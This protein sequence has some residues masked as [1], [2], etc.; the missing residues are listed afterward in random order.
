MIM[1]SIVREAP[2]PAHEMDLPDAFDAV[3]AKVLAKQPDDRF[4]SA[5]EL[6]KALEAAASG[7]PLAATD[8]RAPR[9]AAPGE[10]AV[11]AVR[12]DELVSEPDKAGDEQDGE[13]DDTCRSG[14]ARHWQ[15]DPSWARA[16]ACAR[17]A[18]R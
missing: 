11:T 17:G 18:G 2:L 7:A 14:A 1:M 10:A 13:K 12:V 16:A 5:V 3:F 9:A 4:Q 15:W 6:A 8:T